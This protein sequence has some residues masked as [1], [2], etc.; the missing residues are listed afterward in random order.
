MKTGM[1]RLMMCALVGL[2]GGALAQE[3][4]P[5][6]AAHEPQKVPSAEGIK[7]TWNYF[8]KG[9]G[10]GPVLVDA[11]L[12]TEVGKDGPNKFECTVEVPAEGIKANT[13][14]MVWQAYLLPQGDSAED[15]MVQTKQ[16]SVVRET[17]DV[18]LKGEGWRTRQWT[19]I[20][21]G[22]AGEWTVSI[23]RGDQVLKTF[24]V[25]VL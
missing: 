17:K 1:K 20:R 10:Q 22:K 24:N 23:L 2:S 14:V 9:Q 5:E 4:A 21:L 11:R 8:Y 18:K 13:Q 7:D 25:K 6:A 19:G 15:V 3:A 16:G 12:C